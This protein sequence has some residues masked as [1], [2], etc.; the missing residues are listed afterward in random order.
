MLTEGG[1]VLFSHK[2]PPKTRLQTQPQE[3]HKVATEHMLS[4]NILRRGSRPN[5][6]PVKCNV[7][8]LLV[9]LVVVPVS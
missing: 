3:M 2:I 1:Q 7:V 6:F 5:A 4:C 9:F 8:V